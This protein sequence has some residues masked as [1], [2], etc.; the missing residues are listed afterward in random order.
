[1]VSPLTHEAHGWS[2]LVARGRRKGYRTVLAPDFLADRNLDG[3]L[4]ESSSGD[5]LPP[6]R[7]RTIEVVHNQ[8]GPMFISYKTEQLTAAGLN[9]GSAAGHELPTDEHGRPLEILYGVVARRRLSGPVDDDD[10]QTAR[11]EALR[12]YRR[13]LDQEDGW[14]VAASRSFTLHGVAAAPERAAAAPVRVRTA[15]ATRPARDTR[16]P[17]RPIGGLGLGLVA[18]AVAIA[19]AIAWMVRP[20]PVDVGIDSASARPS[21][22]VVDC[23]APG[24]VRLRGTITS[25]GAATVTYYWEQDDRR[26]TPKLRLKFTGEGSKPA[27][28]DALSPLG[29]ARKGRFVLVVATPDVVRHETPYDLQCRAAPPSAPAVPPTVG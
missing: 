11:G 18:T 16:R 5:D 8:V 28:F 1:V 7:T 20:Q 13:F 25:S 2:F 24:A 22:G 15:A 29:D 6:G 19:F 10:W 3:V 26:V 27:S 12:S 9:G 4:S 14:H 17:M 23:G 21:S